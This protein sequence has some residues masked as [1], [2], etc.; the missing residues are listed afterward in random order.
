[1]VAVH[2]FFSLILELFLHNFDNPKTDN[3]D[4][5]DQK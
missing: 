4:Y 2:L 1:M 5:E 3:D